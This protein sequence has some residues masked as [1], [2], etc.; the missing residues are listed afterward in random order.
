MC[1]S[2]QDKITGWTRHTEPLMQTKSRHGE[3]YSRAAK[4]PHAVSPAPGR[5]LLVRE[6]CL[7][8]EGL[9]DALAHRLRV[10]RP[11][12]QGRVVHLLRLLSTSNSRQ[13]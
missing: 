1:F 8:G 11:L 5:A 6:G 2:V 10:H 9:L 3:V 4:T 13:R 7:V 12:L